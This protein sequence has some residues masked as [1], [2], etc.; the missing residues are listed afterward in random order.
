MGCLVQEPAGAHHGRTVT[1]TP[2]WVSRV[3]HVPFAANNRMANRSVLAEEFFG[4]TGPELV[5]FVSDEAT[6]FDFDYQS[7]DDLR[8]AVQVDYGIVLDELRL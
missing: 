2:A 4:A 8:R 6:W 7:T 1:D 3:D 5:P